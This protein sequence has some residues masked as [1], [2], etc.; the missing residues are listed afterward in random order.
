MTICLVFLSVMLFVL[1][2]HP[3]TTYPLTLKI[4]QRFARPVCYQAL[5]Q[6]L[7]PTEL[8]NTN[9]RKIWRMIN[10]TMTKNDVE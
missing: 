1:A 8:R 3:F 9:I 2:A 4:I 6:E 10:G 5:P 7:L